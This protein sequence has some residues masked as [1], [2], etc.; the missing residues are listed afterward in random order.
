[1]LKKTL[2]S[3][4]ILLICILMAGCVEDQTLQNFTLSE[5]GL[6]GAI[7]EQTSAYQIFE[8]D[9]LDI[10]TIAIK[11]TVL[12]E[13]LDLKNELALRIQGEQYPLVVNPI[14]TDQYVEIYPLNI[15]TM[16]LDRQSFKPLIQ[17]PTKIP[18]NKP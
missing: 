8:Y 12:Q 16:R 17:H 3:I 9:F 4:M 13:R 14:K 5:L 18:W 7:D 15:L 11:R 2:P 1:M 10:Q 6:A